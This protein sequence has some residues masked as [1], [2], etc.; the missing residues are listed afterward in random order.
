MLRNKL[1]IA[2]TIVCLFISI[3]GHAACKG[4]VSLAALNKAN[5]EAASVDYCNNFASSSGISDECA[6]NSAAVSP[7]NKAIRKYK[8]AS[9]GE[10]VATL[11]W[12][13]YESDNWKY[14]INHFPGN[15]GQGTRTMMSWNY[16]SQYAKQLHP[17]EYEQAVGSSGDDV[18]SAN[19]STKT[20]V[21]DLVLNN[22]D[23]FGAGFWYLTTQAP[24]FHNNPSKLRDGNMQDFQE[25][26]Q[27]GIV[28]SWN[29]DREAIWTTVNDAIVF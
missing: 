21:I 1:L 6:L 24:S 5:P 13:L 11:A 12:M 4:L 7:I 22:D 20:A 18:S 26:V 23:S 9:R 27:S 3:G 29:S 16:V 19:N 10:I 2:I 8:V 28:T 25:Y 17:N 15:I 14:N